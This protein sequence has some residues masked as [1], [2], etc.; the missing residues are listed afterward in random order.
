MDKHILTFVGR[1]TTKK[2]GSPLIGK[3]GKPYTSVRIKTN[4]HGDKYLSGFENESTKGWKAG[5]EVEISVEQKGE[6]LNFSTAKSQAGGMS[7]E[8][9]IMLQK[10]FQEVYAA[11]QEIV[12]VRQLLQKKGDI[13][14]ENNVLGL[15]EYP[16]EPNP[17]DIPW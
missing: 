15:E 6:Y 17:A 11:R 14:E 12:M 8:D 7:E 4:A 10:I 5:D 16:D 9:K 2:D 13:P 3:S 1:Y